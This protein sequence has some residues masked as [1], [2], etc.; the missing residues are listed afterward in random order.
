[1]IISIAG[2]AQLNWQPIAGAPANAFRHDDIFFSDVTRGWAVNADGQIWRTLDSG[3]SWTQ[4]VNQPQTYFRCVGFIDSLKGFAGNLGANSWGPSTDTNCLYQTL[5]GGI[6]W[7]PVTNISGP[8]PLGLCGINVFD[9]SVI[10]VCGRVEGPAFFMRSEDGGA[11]WTSTDMSGY[12]QSLVDCYFF[13]RDSGF[14]VGGTDSVFTNSY[15]VV[16]FTSDGG[17]TWS[18]VHTSTHL[19]TH[20][21]K[22]SFPSDNVGYVS[23]ECNTAPYVF[24]KTVNGGQSWQE[25][26]YTTTAPAMVQG[27]GFINDSTGWL[28]GFSRTYFTNDGGATWT[29]SL[30]N[31]KL[32][33]MR[34]IN[35]S[36]G[37]AVG[38]TI[39]RINTSQQVGISELQP[40]GFKLFDVSP[41]P[42]VNMVFIEYEIPVSAQVHIEVFDL[43]GRGVKV[44]TDK[45]MPPGHHKTLFGGHHSATGIYFCT[46]SA[47]SYT[48]TKMFVIQNEY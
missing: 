38:A 18:S 46:M 8:R 43:A 10:N 27:V 19:Q 23:V 3:N 48:E 13:S 35:D 39:Y 31:Q 4:L 26:S 25:M 5:D 21:W 36:M 41:N 34:F 2:S 37:Y 12:A 45:V 1:M 24:L 11:S 9:D 17:N 7:T 42:A 33:R 28:G 15:A 20:C 44:L 22:I 29:G 47:G 6:S 30:L 32:N 16:L 14:V 40:D